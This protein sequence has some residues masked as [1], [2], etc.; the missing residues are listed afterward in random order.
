VSSLGAEI[1]NNFAGTTRACMQAR[2]RLTN[3]AKGG[4]CVPAPSVAAC[5]ANSRDERKDRAALSPGS[6]NVF[7][8]VGRCAGMDRKDESRYP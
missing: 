3:P 2:R 7:P 1:E 5:R 6:G 8:R 4:G